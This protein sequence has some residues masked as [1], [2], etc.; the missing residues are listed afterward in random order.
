[1][2]M[3]MGAYVF[4]TRLDNV[5]TRSLFVDPEHE[6]KL[7]LYNFAMFVGFAITQFVAPIAAVMFPT[8]VRSLALSKKTDALFQT[9]LVTG[10]FAVL[11]AVGCTLF[12]KLPLLVLHF[13][14]E[15]APLVP[16]FAW[17]LLP[18]TLAYVLIQNLLAQ[19]RYAAAPWLILVPVLY[20]LTL[21]AQGPA[22]EAMPPFPAFERVIQTLGLFCLL[23]FAV[24]AW[25]TWR[26]PVAS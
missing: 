22:L 19:G 17:A 1:M 23:L 25:F 11:A 18:L 16:W 12:P 26:K 2:T 14:T 4:M 6:A 13:S 20:G 7:H 10:G 8:I 5:F 9:L 21:M 3:G 24:A 15:A